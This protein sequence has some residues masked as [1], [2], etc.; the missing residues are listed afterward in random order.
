MVP[1]S[2]ATGEA[3]IGAKYRNGTKDCESS[4]SVLLYNNEAQFRN[5][6]I[7]GAK[8]KRMGF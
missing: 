3:A 8:R 2:R 6:H 5:P 7:E 4:R 1:L